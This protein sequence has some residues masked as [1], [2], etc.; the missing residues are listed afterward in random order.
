M[1]F[2]GVLLIAMGMT[3]GFAVLSTVAVVLVP[4]CSGSGIPGVLAFLNG[5]DLHVALRGQVLLAKV[6]GTILAVGGGLALGPEGPMVHIGAIVGMLVC[7]RCLAPALKRLGPFSRNLEEELSR[8]PLRY[9]IQAAVMGAG[10]GI[11]AAFNAPLAGT[12]FVV[13]EAASFFSKKLLL[14]AFISC[15]F[16][17]LTCNVVSKM[18]GLE[19]ETIY[20]RTGAC[21]GVIQSWMDSPWMAFHVAVVGIL[22]GLLGIFFNR[23]VVAISIYFAKE[24]QRMGRGPS[25]FLRRFAFS[26][27]IGSCCGAFAVCLPQS[28]PCLDSSLQNAFH[29]SSGCIMEDWLQQLVS[30]ARYV[31]SHLLPKEFQDDSKRDGLTMSYEPREGLFAAQYDPIRCPSAIAVQLS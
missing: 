3:A 7:R 2:G 13:E 10:A 27:F 29:G 24:A 20:T 1:E 31:P 15:A 11:A 23:M 9:H 5:C 25:L 4:S 6:F 28:Q 14:H 18:A 16:A 26:I 30:G 8:Q 22:C 19:P 12:V 21:V 17:V